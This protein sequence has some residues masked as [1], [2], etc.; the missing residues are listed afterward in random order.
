MGRRIGWV[1]ACCLAFLPMTACTTVPTP[2]GGSQTTVDIQTVVAAAAC[3]SA[4]MGN[5]LLTYSQVQALGPN[6]DPA[7]IIAIA[8]EKMNSGLPTLTACAPLLQK[9]ADGVSQSRP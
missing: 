5:G 9:I 1:A 2:G 3:M 6:P 4:M 7:A 8:Q